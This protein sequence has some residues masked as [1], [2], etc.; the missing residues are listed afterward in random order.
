MSVD[1]GTVVAVFLLLSISN[2]HVEFR[3]C[4]AQLCDDKFWVV[5]FRTL[6]PY[7]YYFVNTDELQYGYL[8][9]YAHREHSVK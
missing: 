4:A 8:Y 3:A 6:D 2:D 5:I 1:V 7:T 9:S